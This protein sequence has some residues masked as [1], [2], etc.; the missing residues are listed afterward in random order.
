MN[1]DLASESTAPPNLA[2]SESQVIAI[3]EE[4]TTEELS[5][6]EE[7]TTI[8]SLAHRVR[9]RMY[10]IPGGLPR[11][12]PGLEV[13]GQIEP[14]EESSNEPSYLNPQPSIDPPRISHGVNLSQ[15]PSLS[16]RVVSS[17]QINLL[18]RIQADLIDSQNLI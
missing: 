11:V 5:S 1:E 9:Q 14:S 2:I 6:E 16:G 10:R 8:G 15:P 3:D 4:E 13:V 12:N 18:Q 17:R 7:H